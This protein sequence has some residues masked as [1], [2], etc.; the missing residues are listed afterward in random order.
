MK[1]IF[2][3]TLMLII[4]ATTVNAQPIQFQREGQE[5]RHHEYKRMADKRNERKQYKQELRD[6]DRERE[7]EHEQ[8]RDKNER[9]EHEHDSELIPW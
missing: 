7:P 1:K 4:G 9:H 5:Y 2:V 8:R 6:T 3:L